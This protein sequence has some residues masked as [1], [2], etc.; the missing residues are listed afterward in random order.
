MSQCFNNY[1]FV[2]SSFLALE[3]DAE[4]LLATEPGCAPPLEYSSCGQRVALSCSTL[5]EQEPASADECVEG[6]FCPDGLALD[7]HGACVEP[8]TCGCYHNHTHYAQE[9]VVQTNECQTW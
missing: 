8:A 5:A 4:G 3:A 6:C 1:T 2:F 9:D 7:E